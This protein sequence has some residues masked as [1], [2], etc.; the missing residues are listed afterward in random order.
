MTPSASVR[1]ALGEEEEADTAAQVESGLEGVP[2][3]VGHDFHDLL[4]LVQGGGGL[5]EGGP[6]VGGV[7]TALQR[8]LAGRSRGT[9]V[10]G[11]QSVELRQGVPEVL[12]GPE[13]RRALPSQAE[14][15]GVVRA[16]VGGRSCDHHL[17]DVCGLGEPPA[18]GEVRG[19]G[20]GVAERGVDARRD[21]H[22]S[23]RLG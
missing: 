12:A 16:E 21:R 6:A 2:G 20:V 13:D 22:W 18:L 23:R 1:R 8:A 15:T 10:Y 11:G 3:R 17:E 19:P 7:P 14:Y 5:A 4:E 9:G